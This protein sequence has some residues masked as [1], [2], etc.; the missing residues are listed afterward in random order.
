MGTLSLTAKVALT[1]K[2]FLSASTWL[3]CANMSR[4]RSEVIILVLSTRSV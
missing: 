4:R 2:G 3:A 1:E